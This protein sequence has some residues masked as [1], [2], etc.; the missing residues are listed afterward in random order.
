MGLD[1]CVNYY[2]KR[3]K[4]IFMHGYCGEVLVTHDY[5]DKQI[6]LN[7]NWDDSYK[8]EWEFLNI[9]DHT[10]FNICTEESIFRPNDLNIAIEKSI[11]Y[12]GDDNKYIDIFNRMKVESDIFLYMSY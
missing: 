9:L 6:K 4:P 8:D 5:S 12:Y 11:K 7:K 3:A 10:F 1:V 2:K